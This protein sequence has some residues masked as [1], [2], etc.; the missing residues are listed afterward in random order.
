[1]SNI[2]G[3][4]TI[5]LAGQERT[6]KANFGCIERLETVILKRG[7]F[8]ALTEALRG[9]PKFSDVVSVIHEGLVASKDTRLSRHEVGEAIVNEGL[10]NFAEIYVE[11]LTYCV[12]GGQKAKGGAAGEQ[13]A[14][15]SL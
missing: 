14:P 3:E 9:T 15:D 11:F 2:R 6:L 10:I 4:F 7:L 1:M 5:K 13:S 8:D 12:T